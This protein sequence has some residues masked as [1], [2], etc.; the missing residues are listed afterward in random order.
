M[1]SPTSILVWDQYV[2]DVIG[3]Q[4]MA[5]RML[6]LACERHRKDLA[7]QDTPEFPYR[8]DEESAR[9]VVRFFSRLILTKGLPPGGKQFIPEPWQQFILASLFGWKRQ[10]GSR[11]F[12]EAHVMVARKNGKSHLWAGVGLYGLMADSEIGAEVY[13]AAT[14][15]DQAKILW[16]AAVEFRRASGNLIQ[17]VALARGSN[18]LLIRETASKFKPLS[19]DVDGMEGLNVHIGLIDELQKHKTRAVYDALHSSILQRRQ[20][21][22]LSIATA[23]VTRTSVC[24]EQREYAVKVLEGVF[25]DETFF[26]F[27]AEADEGDDWEKED[28]WRKAN[29]SLGIPGGVNL[30][31]LRESAKKAKNQPSYLNTFKQRH[32]NIW[33]AQ[34]ECWMPMHRWYECGGRITKVD[35]NDEQKLIVIDPKDRTAVEDAMLAQWRL[36][37][38]GLDLSERGDITALMLLFPPTEKDLHWITLGSYFVPE[39]GVE[40]RVKNDRVPYDVWIREG[41]LFTT[42]G[43]VVDYGFVRA[44][45]LRVHQKLHIQGL[46]VDPHNALQLNKQLQGD[47]IQV[48][49]VQQGWKSLSDPTKNLMAWVLEKRIYHLKDPV[50]SWMMSNVVVWRDAAGNIKP[51]KA[52]ARERI[53]G[54]TALVNAMH[55]A[56][57]RTEG[58][59]TET[60][61]IVSI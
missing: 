30:E 15:K 49:E 61:G 24:W 31:S 3:G 32:L 26:C 20:P 60:R 52:K 51:D 34:D 48:V 45:V 23:G 29:P 5:G 25:Q 56:L 21:L 58:P 37:F 36:P 28:T 13:S 38:A 2:E 35:P 43:E 55:L 9:R 8:F 10:D 27:L 1:E 47:G 6:R 11:R 7:R 22:I 40:D 16:D 59:Y 57:L 53:D 41:Q 42:P 12:R 14:V 18:T 4:I 17:L 44:E 33:T 39:A 54:V 19:S 46:A 50:L